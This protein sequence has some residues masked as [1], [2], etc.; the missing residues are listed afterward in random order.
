MDRV[1]AVA[2]TDSVH[3]LAHQNANKK[4]IKWMRRVR[5]EQILCFSPLTPEDFHVFE[6]FLHSH[7]H[8]IS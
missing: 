6:G 3:S 8:R 1:K 2:F 5:S 4:F 7:A